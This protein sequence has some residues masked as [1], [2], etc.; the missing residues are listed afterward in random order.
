MT[1]RSEIEVFTSKAVDTAREIQLYDQMFVQDGSSFWY[2]YF[3][4]TTGILRLALK[5]SIVLNVCAFFDPPSAAKKQRGENLSLPYMLQKYSNE[6]GEDGIACAAKA[7]AIFESLDLNILRNKFFAHADVD[8]YTS[9]ENPKDNSSTES[10]LEVC[11]C[12][13]EIGLRLENP[14]G[15]LTAEELLDASKLGPP[16]NGSTLT[17]LLRSS[18][19]GGRY[20]G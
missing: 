12:L 1:L 6:L 20:S 7:R 8:F 3:F 18:L 9:G 14:T 16:D 2:D 11:R 10:Y 19:K 4:D 15:S 13:I 5:K 17:E